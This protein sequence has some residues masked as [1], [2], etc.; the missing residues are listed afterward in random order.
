MLVKNITELNYIM[1]QLPP[2]KIC[3]NL[4]NWWNAQ[5]SI[6][7]LNQLIAHYGSN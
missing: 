7:H 4:L 5:S 6:C 3:C 1:Q 2:E